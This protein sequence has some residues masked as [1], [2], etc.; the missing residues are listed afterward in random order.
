MK[1]LP[2]SAVEIKWTKIKGVK[3]ILRQLLAEKEFSSLERK[4]FPRRSIH[5]KL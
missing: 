5:N 2:Q 3:N 4:S 1:T